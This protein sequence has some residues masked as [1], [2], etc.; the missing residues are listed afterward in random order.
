VNTFGLFWTVVVVLSA[1]LTVLISVDHMRAQGAA[2]GEYYA[3]LSF[4]AAGM[5]TIALAADLIVLF[6]GIEMMSLSVYVLAGIKRVSPY[7]AEAALKYFVMGAVSSAILL[8]GIALLY[9][10]GGTTNLAALG[11]HFAQHPPTAANLIPYAAL[12]LLIAGF[13]FKVAA[14]PFHLWTP[15]AYEGAPTPVTAFMAAGVKAASFAAF[16][17]VLLMVFD[18]DGFRAM[19]LPW[20]QAVVV[21]AVLTMTVGNL[22]ALNQ[23]NVKRMLAYS[24]IAHAGYLLL[25]FLPVEHFALAGAGGGVD[26]GARF[27]VPSSALFYYLF[28]YAVANLGAFG[29]IAL[30]GAKGEE[31][32]NLGR[33]SGLARR[34]PVAAVVLTICL[35]SLAGIP[36]TAGFVGKWVLFRD[37]L[38]VGDGQYLWLVIVA[39]LNSL[40]SVYYYLRPTVAMYFHPTPSPRPA[41][42]RTTAGML[43]VVLAALITL[44]AG[45]L[46]GRYLNAARKAAA[47]TVPEAARLVLQKA[48]DAGSALPGSSPNVPAPPGP[49]P[50]RPLAQR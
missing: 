45:I 29:V 35:L 5:I 38:K 50:P 16:F 39:V 18:G 13:G 10:A 12:L 41:L 46:P 32:A 6:I 34:R 21:L 48:A 37:V 25:A 11:A 9:G 20:E 15:D 24:S 22:I 43:A 31:D 40:V 8:Y 3:L 23:D 19:A 17:R 1:L 33:L 42:L 27:A 44:H 2:H 14:V 4:A 47:G 28:V 49:P 7:G 30:L 26:G 36:P